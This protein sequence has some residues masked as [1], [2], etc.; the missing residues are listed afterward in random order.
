VKNRRV[1]SLRAV[2][3][4]STHM[5]A[6]LQASSALDMVTTPAFA[7]TKNDGENGSALA[8]RRAIAATGGNAIPGDRTRADCLPG[9]NVIRSQLLSRGRCDDLSTGHAEGIRPWQR[10][11]VGGCETASS[12][13]K[14][15]NYSGGARR[16][17]LLFARASLKREREALPLGGWS[18]LMSQAS[19]KYY[20]MVRTASSLLRGRRV[21]ILNVMRA[22]GRG[23]CREGAWLRPHGFEPTRGWTSSGS[24]CL[25]SGSGRRRD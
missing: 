9:A 8:R 11:A 6:R 13:A 5:A 4:R 21:P 17:P 18:S 7:H 25:G 22:D 15:R 3:A 23:G 24:Y 2:W 16:A 20:D 1:S 14:A 12:H 10:R 19:M